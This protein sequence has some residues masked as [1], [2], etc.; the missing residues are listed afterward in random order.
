MVSQSDINEL[1][2]YC[3]SIAKG[4]GEDL[5]QETLLIAI[6]QNTTDIPYMKRIARNQFYN[7]SSHFSKLHKEQ[8]ICHY[9]LSI[10]QREADTHTEKLQQLVNQTPKTKREL[11]LKEIFLE[12]MAVGSV[13]RVAQLTGIPKNTIQ[14]AIKRYKDDISTKYNSILNRDIS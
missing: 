1:R 14:K 9:T 12:Y 11:F 4:L 10:V 8:K 13:K 2:A 6:E 5:C 7:S 3:L